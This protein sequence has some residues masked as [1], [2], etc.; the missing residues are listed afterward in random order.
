ML[1]DRIN[2]HDMKKT[3]LACHGTDQGT[4]LLKPGNNLA[5]TMV[6]SIP[7]FPYNRGARSQKSE[8]INSRE[9]L[10]C[11]VSNFMSCHTDVECDEVKV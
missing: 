4:I 5:T 11:K 2:W 3:I 9:I 6:L 10:V 7:Y 1:H 8:C